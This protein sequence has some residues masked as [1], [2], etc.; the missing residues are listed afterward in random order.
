MK[1]ID[2]NINL[3]LFGC[4]YDIRFHILLIINNNQSKEWN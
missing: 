3:F 2:L 4:G 1:I